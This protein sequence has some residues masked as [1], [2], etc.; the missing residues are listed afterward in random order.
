MGAAEWMSGRHDS[1]QNDKEILGYSDE[2]WNFIWDTMLEDG[3]WAVPDIKDSLGNTIKGNHAPEMFIKYIA[4]DLQCHI[5]V[6]DLLLGQVQFCSANH[7]KDENVSFDSPILLYTTG[8]HF[9]SVFPK[10]QEYFI[11]F[12]RELEESHSIIPTHSKQARSG[13]NIPIPSESSLLHGVQEHKETPKLDPRS[14]SET[15][16]FFKKN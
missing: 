15:E 9:Q 14:A 3:A 5:I 16:G 7:V 1:K 2:E 8:G 10:D 6:F 12:A 11:N 4:H 13:E